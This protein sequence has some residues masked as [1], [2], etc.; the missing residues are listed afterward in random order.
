MLEETLEDAM[1]TL[2]IQHPHHLP[3]ERLRAHLDELAQTLKRELDLDYRW[4]GDR[5][6]FQRSGASGHLEVDDEQVTLELTLGLLLRPLKGHIE[7][8][9]RDYLRRELPP[10]S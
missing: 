8:K 9:V 7:D 5:L 2:R 6:L 1:T 10:P 3:R 4:E